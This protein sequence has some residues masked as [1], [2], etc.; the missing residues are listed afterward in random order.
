VEE[1]ENEDESGFTSMSNESPI[2]RQSIYDN[3]E[4]D[5]RV[6]PLIEVEDLNNSP[7]IEIP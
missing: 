3:S 2:G 7:Q 5:E 4:N 6:M 1:E